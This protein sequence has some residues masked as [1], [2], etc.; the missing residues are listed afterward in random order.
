MSRTISIPLL[1]FVLLTAACGR[2]AGD[3]PETGDRH[4]ATSAAERDAPES[5]AVR[6]QPARLG[7]IAY[8]L[9]T[10]GD[11]TA[12]DW[13][14]LVVRRSG[15]VEEIL[16]EEGAAVRAGE[17]LLVLDQ[18]EAEIA[19]S[20]AKNEEE[21][22]A[23]RADLSR[24]S[25]AASEN[26]LAQARIAAEKAEAEFRRYS[27]LSRGVIQQEELATRAYEHQRARLAQEAVAGELRQSRISA[28]ISDNQAVAAALKRKKALLDFEFTVLTAPFPGV[29]SA[30]HVQRG[31]FLSAN[32]R[33]FTLVD[34][35]NLKLE[36][37]LPQRYLSK[38][39]PG[40][41][42]R[43]ETEAFPGREFLAATER[44]SPVV[45]EKGT[46]KV[47][48]RVHEPDGSLRPGMYVSASIELD[49][50]DRTILTPK[51]GVQYDT[52][53]GSPHV[54]VVRDGIARLLPVR[55]G[56][57]ESEEVETLP[58]P[59]P[60][61]WG[62]AALT[63]GVRTFGVLI[64]L[65]RIVMLRAGDRVIVAGQDKLRGGETVRTVENATRREHAGAG[66]KAPSPAASSPHGSQ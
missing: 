21:E 8:R 48:I 38:L 23:R 36:V 17:R 46:V 13:V 7:S 30:R 41:P 66:S 53:G 29:I 24:E 25:V 59:T 3:G 39:K 4:S 63:G 2:T 5:T 57:R 56:Y 33:G 62:L 6:T 18:R 45:G 44:I 28:V 10:T 26:A 35:A 47:T 49:T 52:L 31:Q 12:E 1:T 32:A 54:F 58:V 51:R 20:Q 22:A 11:L 43:L 65:P 19:L 9:S 14:D 27:R 42:V 55:I 64:P 60:V 16:V 50:H 37:N 61:Y 15:V 40:L 34:A